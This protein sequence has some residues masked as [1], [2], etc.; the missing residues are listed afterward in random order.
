MTAVVVD[1]E[2]IV[3][4]RNHRLAEGKNAY[5]RAFRDVPFNS[6]RFEK[7]LRAH[8]PQYLANRIEPTA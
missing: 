5:W 3:C 6:N 2:L 8:A 4:G 1:G 7:W